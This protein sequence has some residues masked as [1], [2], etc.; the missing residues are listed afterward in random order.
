M[1]RQLPGTRGG[2]GRYG[3]LGTEFQFGKMSKV[4]KTDGGDGYQTTF[5]HLMPL[6]GKILELKNS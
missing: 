4:L 1:E 2:E 5:R 3:V 6:N